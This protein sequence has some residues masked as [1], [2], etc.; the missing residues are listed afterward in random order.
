M[1]RSQPGPHIEWRLNEG[2]ALND[3]RWP[4]QTKFSLIVSTESI[5]IPT[6][7]VTTIWHH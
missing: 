6:A 5:R 2:R 4:L 3:V 1:R 7:M